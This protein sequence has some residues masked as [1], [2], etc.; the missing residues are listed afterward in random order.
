MN[1]IIWMI[2]PHL[3]IIMSEIPTD[4]PVAILLRHSVRPPMP[5]QGHGNDLLLTED[6]HR[7][8]HE[9][10][11]IFGEKLCSLHS[12][13][14]QRCIQTAEALGVGAQKT[15]P[16]R[17]DRL[18]GDPGV[19]VLDGEVAG[20][21]WQKRGIKQTIIDLM[22]IDEPLPGMAAP[23]PAARFL[24]QHMLE[25]SGDIA[26]Y[27]VFVTHDSVQMITASCFLPQPLSDYHWPW[28][29]DAIFFWRDGESIGMAYKDLRIFIQNIL[30]D[31]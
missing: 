3:P 8:A 15:L 21:Y 6:G 24:V 12:S 4:V 30:L 25:V 22:Q 11:A 31:G 10:G 23:A 28:F 2:P 29:L 19:F 17:Q 18:L 26:G 13:P 16:I 1:S 5:A 14:I 20:A 27:H 7:I 9:L